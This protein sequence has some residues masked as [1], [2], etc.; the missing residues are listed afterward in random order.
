MVDQVQHVGVC[1]VVNNR[2][3][4]TMSLRVRTHT[5]SVSDI[6]MDS[7]KVEGLCFPLLFPHGE[8]GYTNA[9]KSCMSPDEY[10][11]SRLLMPEKIGVNFMTAQAIYAP[12]EC[13]DSRTGEELVPTEDP[14]QID[15]H[16]VQGVSIRRRL[17]VN[18]FMLMARLAQYWLMDFI[19]KSLIRE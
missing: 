2:Q 19:L 7:E 5:N 16:Q 12:F 9:S 3:T 11:M 6:N 15:E 17:R 18:C 4:G 13:I 14:S 10:V 1:S 8:L